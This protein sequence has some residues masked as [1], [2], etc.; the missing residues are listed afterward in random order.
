[1]EIDILSL[2][3]IEFE[4]YCWYCRGDGKAVAGKQCEHCKGIGKQTTAIGDKLITFLKNRGVGVITS[5]ED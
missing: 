5:K 3:D 1:M 2:D 4:E